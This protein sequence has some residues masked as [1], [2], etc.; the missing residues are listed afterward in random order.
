MGEAAV[1]T[2]PMAQPAA[3]T[4][5]GA[6]VGVA[7]ELQRRAGEGARLES[8]CARL[9]GL[10]GLDER[11]MEELQALDRVTQHLAALARYVG[12]LSD[13]PAAA[14]EVDLTAALRAVP[15]A[16]LARSLEK[17]E[18]HAGALGDAGDFELF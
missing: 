2:A 18:P 13:E 3:H 9:A 5:A 10:A 4:L 15:L 11:A 8:T 7:D 1:K 6:L 14:H 12:V 17:A 16:A